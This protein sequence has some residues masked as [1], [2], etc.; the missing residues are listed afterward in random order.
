MD[1]ARLEKKKLEEL[2]QMARDMEVS[3]HNR[4][5]K[6][7]LVLALL[8]ANAEKKGLMLRGGVLEVVDDGI[9]FLRSGHLLPGRDDVYVS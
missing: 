9:G 3:G 6:D 2:R 8:R 1:I 7:K 4:L 5:K